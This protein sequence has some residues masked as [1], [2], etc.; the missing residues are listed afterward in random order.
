MR[1][2]GNGWSTVMTIPRGRGE[3]F[4]LCCIFGLAWAHEARG[5]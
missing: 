2:L 3:S 4:G 1:T 5:T